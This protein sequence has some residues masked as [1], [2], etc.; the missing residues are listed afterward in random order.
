MLNPFPLPVYEM[1]YW[2]ELKGVD[3]WFMLKHKSSSY[4][5]LFPVTLIKL[6][7]SAGNWIVYLED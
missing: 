6:L 7:S 3:L 5:L 2:S 1:K 4:C